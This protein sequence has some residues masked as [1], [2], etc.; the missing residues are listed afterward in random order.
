MSLSVSAFVCLLV[1]CDR[2]VCRK[3]TCQLRWQTEVILGAHYHR[4]LLPSG[5]LDAAYANFV[6]DTVFAR[7]SAAGEHKGSGRDR[8]GSRP[9]LDPEPHA[10]R[11]CPERG[12]LM[13][14]QDARP[15]P[16]CSPRCGHRD[17]R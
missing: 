17:R 8:C 13:P 16:C 6:V 7:T 3:P 9:P 5:P 14:M 10:T 1:R 4:L 12:D 11:G 15:R 2:L